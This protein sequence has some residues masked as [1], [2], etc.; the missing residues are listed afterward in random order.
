MQNLISFITR[1]NTFFLFLVLQFIVFRVISSHRVFQNSTMFGVSSSVS[2][3]IYTSTTDVNQYFMLKNL[4][5]S[6]VLENA[7]LKQNIEDYL[8]GKLNSDTLPAKEGYY[9]LLRLIPTK[10]IRNSV[11]VAQNNYLTLDK[12]SL[13]GVKKDM[14]VLSESGIVGVVNGVSNNY[15]SVVP[16][17]HQR[18]RTS[19]RIKRNNDVGKIFW[20]GNS[21]D[22]LTMSDIGDYSD[23]ITGDTII[24]TSYSSIFP[25]GIPIGVVTEVGKQPGS[26]YYNLEIQPITNF[27]NLYYVYVVENIL[28]EERVELEQTFQSNE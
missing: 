26:N 10:V 9:N 16:L 25:E 1:Y 15:A 11:E 14:A 18:F 27:K 8:P 13:Q 7:R 6:L 22:V 12:G 28:Q 20:D 4:N 2:G 17:F 5:D 21:P 24:T 23:V 3:W 19:G